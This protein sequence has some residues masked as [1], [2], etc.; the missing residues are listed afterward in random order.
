M[1]DLRLRGVQLPQ[2][3]LAFGPYL[4]PWL[5]LPLSL[6][7]ATRRGLWER[8]RRL[9]FVQQILHATDC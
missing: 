3:L 1:P 6:V 4:L 7:V 5:L 8:E 9:P 2:T